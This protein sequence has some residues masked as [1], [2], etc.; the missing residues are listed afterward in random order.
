M[1][2]VHLPTS[3][4][5]LE[6][7]LM[8]LYGLPTISKVSCLTFQSHIPVPRS[9]GEP[10]PVENPETPCWIPYLFKGS[11]TRSLECPLKSKVASYLGVSNRWTGFF[12]ETW[13]WNIKTG[14]CM[15]D[16]NLKTL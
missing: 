11:F 1:G 10:S 2:Y 15:R 7:V 4:L 13:D 12:T 3:G 6:R 16:W 14:M 9:S 8:V 5:R